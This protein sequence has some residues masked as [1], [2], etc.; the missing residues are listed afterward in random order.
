MNLKNVKV[1][2]S[3]FEAIEGLS[4]ES[5]L[6]VRAIERMEKM[7]PEI[8][9]L[10]AKA[11]QLLIFGA[12]SLE[13]SVRALINDQRKIE[14]LLIPGSNQRYVINILRST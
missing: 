11:S 5:C 9:S 2:E 6:T 12:K 4:E 3:R 7:I 8:L 10:G 14:S 1:I 13:K